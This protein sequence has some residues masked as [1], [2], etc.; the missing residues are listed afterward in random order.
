MGGS[1]GGGGGGEGVRPPP[2]PPRFSEIRVFAM[3]QFFG[4]P[5]KFFLFIRAC[6]GLMSEIGYHSLSLAFPYRFS[7]NLV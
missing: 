1:G 7:S 5:L 3:I 4:P 6:L 2:P